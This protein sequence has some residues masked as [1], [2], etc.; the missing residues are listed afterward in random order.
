MRSLMQKVKW[1]IHSIVSWEDWL[2]NEPICC[3]WA[4]NRE[5]G[6]IPFE[7]ILR[8][9]NDLVRCLNR[10]PQEVWRDSA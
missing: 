1:G 5:K 7:V 6:V 4:E 3:R 9:V 10:R 2:V 8:E